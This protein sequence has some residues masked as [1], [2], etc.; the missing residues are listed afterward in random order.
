MTFIVYRYTDFIPLSVPVL[1]LVRQSRYLIAVPRIDVIGFDFTEMSKHA[2]SEVVHTTY[3]FLTAIDKGFHC[4]VVLAGSEGF[5]MLFDTKRR[6]LL[7][8][9]PSEIRVMLFIVTLVVDVII[10][11]GYIASSVYSRSAR[12]ARYPCKYTLD[13]ENPTYSIAFKSASP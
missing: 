10:S 7:A 2:R 5:S 6:C 11:H 1:S 9:G 3:A 4:R 12:Y 13:H 8:G